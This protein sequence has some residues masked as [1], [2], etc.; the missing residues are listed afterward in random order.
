[1]RLRFLHHLTGRYLRS[2]RAIRASLALSVVG[3]RMTTAPVEHAELPAFTDPTRPVCTCGRRGPI[4]VHFDRNCARGT[5]R[6]L[7]PRVPVRASLGRALHGVAARA[8]VSRP[9]TDDTATPPRTRLSE[10]RRWTARD[11]GQAPPV[12]AHLGTGENAA[13]VQDNGFGRRLRKCGTREARF[14]PSVARCSWVPSGAGRRS[15][16]LQARFAQ[17]ER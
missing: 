8:A 5:R 1:M 6:P 14:S 17:C 16:V 9:P 10:L 12:A 2:R 15:G 4:R 13:N 3:G 7:P 11:I